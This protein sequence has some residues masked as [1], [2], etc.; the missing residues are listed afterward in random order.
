MVLTTFV[1]SAYTGRVTAFDQLGTEARDAAGADLDLRSTLELV[2][3]M[4]LEDATVPPA[5]AAAAPAIAELI[6]AVS[7]RLAAG[8]RLVYA[9]AG[10]SGRLAALD[11]VECQTTFSA[12]AGQVVG[13][14]AGGDAVSAVAQEAAEDDETAGVGDLRALALSSADAVVG[15]SASGRSP[16]VRGVLRAANDVGAVTGCIVCVEG[17]EL[18]VL[19]DHEVSV[20]VG[21]EV[22]SGSTRLKAGTAQKLVLNMVST[23]SM[24]RLGKT[25][26]NL[27]VDVEATNEKLRARV[28]SIVAYATGEPPE[29]V[30]EA[31]VAADGSA[32]VAIVSLLTGLDAS[33]ARARLDEAGGVVR[34][35]LEL[36]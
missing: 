10:T 30:G 18:A 26:G 11:A 14:V 32:K 28:R 9:G 27:M 23:I 22:V 3:L 7:A 21:A 17:S 12:Q 24:I 13:L 8:G 34:R 19:A 1:G 2:E 16:Y 31:L 20:P 36:R 5:V 29:R 6:D 15:V 25:Y 35:A 33:A 4:S